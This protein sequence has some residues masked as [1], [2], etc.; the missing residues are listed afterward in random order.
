M[1]SATTLTALK[2]AMAKVTFPLTVF[3]SLRT[4]PKSPQ[5]RKKGGDLSFC[6]LAID[7][8]AQPCK[9]SVEVGGGTRQQRAFFTSAK[10]KRDHC[11][12]PV[13]QT[14]TIAS[15]HYSRCTLKAAVT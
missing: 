4:P 9:I 6:G 1:T 2:N 14:H 5:E 11:P 7:S 10:P 8:K 15:A 3:S 13:S 12:L